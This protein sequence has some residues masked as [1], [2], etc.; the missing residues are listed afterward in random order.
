MVKR[1]ADPKKLMT[2]GLFYCGAR[3]V[4]FVFQYSSCTPGKE[5]CLQ[6]LLLLLGHVEWHIGLSAASG[7]L[8]RT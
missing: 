1:N 7:G 5:R 3:K 2:Q 4:G 6:C 8:V